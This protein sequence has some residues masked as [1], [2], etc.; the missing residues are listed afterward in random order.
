MTENTAM[1]VDLREVQEK[2]EDSVKQAQDFGRK[3]FL[4][5][6]GMWGLAY[7]KG[8]EFWKYGWDLVDKAEKRGEEIEMEW[9]KQFDKLQENP[10]VKKVVD[11]V[12]DQVDVV[13]KNAKS[14]VAEAEKFLGQFQAKGEEAAKNVAIEVEAVMDAVLPGY[15]E[16]SAKDIVVQLTD[17]PK[18]KL[19]EIREYEVKNKNRVTVLREID[20]MLETSDV[21]AA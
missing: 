14:V 8:Q 19:I 21:V 16:M 3:M 1:N 5:S 4:A 17:L 7:D 6:V 10:E 20:A 12:E 11:Y 18:G 15:D 13:S 9:S 2:V